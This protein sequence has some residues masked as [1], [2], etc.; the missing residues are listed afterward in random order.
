MYLLEKE[1]KSN[2]KYKSVEVLYNTSGLGIADTKS[3]KCSE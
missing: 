2:H 1:L 3:T